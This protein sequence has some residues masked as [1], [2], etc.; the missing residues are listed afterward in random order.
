[1]ADESQK[2]SI[3]IPG[4]W[5]LQRAF[6][7]VLTELGEDLK[8][9][10]AVGRDK[11]LAAGYKKIRDLDDGKKANLRVTRDVLWN[12]AFTDDAI[13]A[14]YFGGILAA[15]RSED[16]KDDSAIHFVDVIKSMSSKQLE[17]HYIIYTALNRM[18]SSSNERVNVGQGSELVRKAIFFS[19]FELVQRHQVNTDTDLN[20]LYRQGL[21]SNYKTHLYT[22][23]DGALA[24][25]AAHPTTYGVL[26]YAAAHNRRDEWR[27]FDRQELGEFDDIALPEFFAPTLQE[28]S[29]LMGLEPEE[30][31]EE[32]KKE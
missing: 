4:E 22:V 12:G 17:L 6:G 21:L 2:L 20:I 28:L 24:Y 15:S 13:C 29:K 7:P 30:Q 23:R 11:I 1:M 10:Y 16:G 26:L 32:K 31:P 3:A 19:Q 18:L 27:S 14:E 8:R 5:A 9:L 25:V